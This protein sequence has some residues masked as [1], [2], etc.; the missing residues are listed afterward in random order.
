MALITPITVWPTPDFA[1]YFDVQAGDRKLSARI[2]NAPIGGQDPIAFLSDDDE[3]HADMI[4]AWHDYPD[5]DMLG[6]YETA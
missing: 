2:L 4:A 6:H 5:A 1:T 3:T